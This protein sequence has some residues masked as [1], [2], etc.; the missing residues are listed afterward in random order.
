MFDTL[1]N[2]IILTQE[3][4]EDLERTQRSFCKLITN[5]KFTSYEDMLTKLNLTKLPERWKYLNLKI[6]KD[7]LYNEKLT[8]LFPLY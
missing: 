6:A 3:N 2:P 5:Y 8:D 1:I 4:R 7:G